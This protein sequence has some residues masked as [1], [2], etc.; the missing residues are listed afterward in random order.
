MIIILGLSPAIDITYGLE[1]LSA[2]KSNRVT[3][4]LK[5]AGG[6]A[7]NVARVV[8]QLGGK[9]H[10]IV[11]LGGDSGRWI[12]TELAREGL[13]FAKIAIEADT[14][15]TVTVFDGEAT[16]INEPASQLSQG[17]LDA[18]ET[19]LITEF[20][21]AANSKASG[22]KSIFV[23]SGSIP[24]NVPEGFLPK[25]VE[26]AQKRAI[27]SIVDVSGPN[28]LLAARAKP[29][30]LKPNREELM[31]AVNSPNLEASVDKLQELGAQN[32]LVTDGAKGSTWFFADGTKTEGNSIPGVTGNPTGAGDALLAALCVAFEADKPVADALIDGLAAGAAAVNSPVAGEI[33]LET[34][35]TLR[36]TVNLET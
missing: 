21:R 3:S 30:L 28:I 16:V 4:I 14:R 5:R 34:F 25:L 27:H 20:D 24:K 17:E 26:Q 35:K 1:Q 10:L 22:E 13:S 8:Q 33:D 9:A 6:K 12:T 18:I 31:E 15:Q 11:P 19:A 32:V 29:F 7:V 2:G 36:E 23:V